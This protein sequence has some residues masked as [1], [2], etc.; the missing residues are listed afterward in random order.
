MWELVIVWSNGDKDVYQYGT[1]EEAEEAESGMGTAFGNQIA[2]TGI[3]R[4][5]KFI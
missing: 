3:R 2:W 4:T 1:R 5:D